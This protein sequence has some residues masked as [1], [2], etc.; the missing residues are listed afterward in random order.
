MN[1]SDIFRIVWNGLIWVG[2]IRINVNWFG[3]IVIPNVIF[4][5]PNFYNFQIMF[6]LRIFGNVVASKVLT[7]TF[8]CA[9]QKYPVGKIWL[10]A[11]WVEYVS[12][13]LTSPGNLWVWDYDGSRWVHYNFVIRVPPKINTHFVTTFTTAEGEV[14]ITVSTSIN[15]SARLVSTHDEIVNQLCTTYCEIFRTYIYLRQREMLHY[16]AVGVW[17]F[18]K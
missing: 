18:D 5:S 16:S 11:E 13:T 10:P 9:I 1:W 15:G 7:F 4:F 17:H 8:R 12:S 6:A 2:V 3:I 14:L